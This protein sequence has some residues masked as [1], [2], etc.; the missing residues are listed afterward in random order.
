MLVDRVR[1][2]S[3]FIE[4]K[5]QTT[6]VETGTDISTNVIGDDIQYV[7]IDWFNNREFLVFFHV[8]GE[9]VKS[10]ISYVYKAKNRL[11][12]NHSVGTSSP[13]PDTLVLFDY[14]SFTILQTQ[15]A[16][17]NLLLDD[18]DF[19]EKHGALYTRPNVPDSPYE[20]YWAYPRDEFE[21][22]WQKAIFYSVRDSASNRIYIIQNVK[23]VSHPIKDVSNHI[24]IE[25]HVS[26][27]I[28]LLSQ[29]FIFGQ[30]TGC[31]IG[32]SS[33]INIGYQGEIKYITPEGELTVRDFM[34]DVSSQEVYFGNKANAEVRNDFGTIKS[35]HESFPLDWKP[36][37]LEYDEPFREALSLHSNVLWLLGNVYG[38]IVRNL[39][40]IS[41]YISINQSVIAQ[42]VL[43][44]PTLTRGLILGG[45]YQYSDVRLGYIDKI[46]Y[47]DRTLLQL[48]ET[49]NTH[50]SG[51]V[52]LSHQVAGYTLGG[53]QSGSISKMI[54]GIKFSNY[55]VW[56]LNQ[57]LSNIRHSGCGC[58]SSTF[59]YVIAGNNSRMDVG[60]IE[61]MDFHSK[62]VN[63]QNEYL[64]VPRQSP[65]GVSGILAGYAVS[66]CD[67]FND[68]FLV[69]NVDK[70]V[71]ASESVGTVID[72]LS[73]PRQGGVGLQSVGKGYIIGGASAWSTLRYSTIDSLDFYTDSINT[74]SATISQSKEG[75]TGTN[76]YSMGFIAGSLGS[77]ESFNFNV[78]KVGLTSMF[79]SVARRRAVG[80]QG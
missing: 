30:L 12:L 44:V 7:P 55:S 63:I 36:E 18:L 10:P 49:L 34:T 56:I 69:K 74:V 25:G 16:V 59:G 41:N 66:G 4:E 37:T 77:I 5:E 68:Y 47:E 2:C 11:S 40:A 39:G 62:S 23:I 14:A 33:S 29:N 51:S 79:L 48:S 42:T 54:E 78:E 61:R 73:V 58:Y 52:G 15:N 9:D 22:F 35:K 50:T 27:V 76:W 32:D 8:N 67:S 65:S 21:E 43:K 20:P 70:L 60:L 24:Q 26:P 38:E 75:D 57:E 45:S 71:F 64:S 80:V 31:N 72:M 19:K 28:N 46:R 6:A 13:T 17:N 53:F 3:T 1:M